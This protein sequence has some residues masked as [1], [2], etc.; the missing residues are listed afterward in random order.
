MEPLRTRI[1]EQVLYLPLPAIEYLRYAG[2]LHATPLR[3][4]HELLPRL[5]SV[6]EYRGVALDGLYLGQ[7]P[8]R[9]VRTAAQSVNRY[10]VDVGLFPLA[11]IASLKAFR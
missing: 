7:N 2:Q 8:G 6:H 4:L 10:E 3:H 11:L 9:R 1:G 5:V